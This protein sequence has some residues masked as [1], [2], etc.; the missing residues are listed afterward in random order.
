LKLAKPEQYVVLPEVI[1]KEPLG[2]AVRQG[3]EA[4]FNIVRWTLYGLLNAEELGVTSSNV[5]RQARD[6]R[7]P[8][9]ARLLGSEG[10]AGKDLQ[11]P[12]DWVVQMVRQVG[13]YG[14]IF[15]R[16]VGDG[17][18]LKMP[19]G[20]NAQWNLGGLHYAPPIR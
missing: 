6:S 15:A 13:N 3:D 10:D 17:S 20:L 4:W 19:R 16:N 8:D 9:V 14:E 18:P 7:N 1:S 5:E 11:L 12:R 2:P